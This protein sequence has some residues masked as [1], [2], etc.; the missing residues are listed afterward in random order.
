MTRKLSRR[1]TL[2]AA[3]AALPRFA[4]AQADT[5]PA[6]SVAVQKIANTGVLDLLREQSSNASERW[7]ASILE[8]PIA[9][10]QQGRLER[11][12]GLATAWRRIDASTVELELRQGVK[13]HNGTNSPPRTS[14][15]PSAPSACSVRICPRTFPPLPAGISPHSTACRPP[16]AIPCAS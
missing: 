4:I 14:P 3:T 8:T 15:S 10:N 5:R 6:I 9:R 1:A 11:V 13:L 12:P 7:A 2:A 16:G